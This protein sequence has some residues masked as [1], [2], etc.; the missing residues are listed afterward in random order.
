M[1]LRATIPIFY[2]GLCLPVSGAALT[3]P[4]RGRHHLCAF[5]PA[6]VD[7]HQCVSIQPLLHARGGVYNIGFLI[8]W[9]STH[10]R[11]FLRPSTSVADRRR[12]VASPECI[13][14]S[15]LARLVSEP[16]S[17]STIIS[18]HTT[19]LICFLKNQDEKDTYKVALHR[20]KSLIEV[21]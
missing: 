16:E 5:F 19:F 18:E 17:L 21:S 13:S 1:A 11:G 10:S 20:I 7:R 3:P 6:L 8:E 9:F 15:E 4:A 12:K 14:P 2:F